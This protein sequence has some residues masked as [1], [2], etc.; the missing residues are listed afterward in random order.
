M[1]QALHVQSSHRLAAGRL[2]PQ[3]AA[4]HRHSVGR[5]QRLVVAAGFLNFLTPKAAAPKVDER[6]RELAEALVEL[7]ESTS[8]GSKATPLMRDEIEE[9]VCS[10]STACC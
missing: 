7:C 4:P 3:R 5:Q 6:G 8:E 2:A 10:D 1:S 9:L